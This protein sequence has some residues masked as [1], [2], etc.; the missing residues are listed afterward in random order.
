MRKSRK[1]PI[2]NP[3]NH[4][5]KVGWNLSGKNPR[6]FNLISKEITFVD[7]KY[8]KHV[9]RTLGDAVFDS[10][11]DT[12]VRRDIQMKKILKLITPKV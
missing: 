2:Y 9:K 12:K 7:K 4:D 11:G 6:N 10:F 3:L 8:E 5:V 1:V